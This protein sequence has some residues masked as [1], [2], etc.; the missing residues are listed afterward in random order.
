MSRPDVWSAGALALLGLVMLV[1]AAELEIGPPTRPG[2]GFFPAVLAAAL[3]LVAL[4]IMT[5]AWRAPAVTPSAA[6]ASERT[7]PR[8]LLATLG[9]FVA[10][11][12]VF[13]RLGFLVATVALLAFL[14]GTL[15][16]YRWPVAL[17]AAMGMAI[18]AYL[19]FDTWL[20]LR[21]PP[22]VLGRW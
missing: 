7:D 22:G 12:T 3:L 13:E 6:P 2:P 21:L 20:Q 15:G 16:G 11:V 18:G 19:V 8:K 5:M 10:Y 1:K 9:A 4:A 14:L 17:G